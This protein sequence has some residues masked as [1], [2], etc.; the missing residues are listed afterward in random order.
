LF[1]QSEFA[2]SLLEFFKRGLCKLL[3]LL[4]VFLL[5]LVHFF[6]LFVSPSKKKKEM[7]LG[8]EGA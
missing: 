2:R 3:L 5:S 4:W 1:E 7:N 6:L 8:K